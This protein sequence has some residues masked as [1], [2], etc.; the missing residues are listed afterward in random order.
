MFS[1]IQFKKYVTF[2]NKLKK[3]IKLYKIIKAL[4][5][6]YFNFNLNM[7]ILTKSE[8]ASGYYKI[9]TLLIVKDNRYK[10]VVRIILNFKF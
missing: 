7:L 9:N 5:L 4:F 6:K 2:R 8:N 10:Q 1:L 3:T